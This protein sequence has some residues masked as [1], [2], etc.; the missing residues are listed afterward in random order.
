[1]VA[2]GGHS[3]EH[4]SESI[5][6]VTLVDELT[7]YTAPVV[8]Q[9]LV[10][11][12][13]HGRIF[14]VLDLTLVDFIDSTGTGVLVGALKRVRAHGGGLALVAPMERIAKGFRI[15]GLTK[16]FPLLDSVDLAVEFLG[17]ELGVHA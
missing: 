9:L 17:R 7:V 8:R 4:V 3:Y 6:V 13:N 11:L 5:T 1:M 10:D 14:L 16:V 12:I 2:Q 15:T